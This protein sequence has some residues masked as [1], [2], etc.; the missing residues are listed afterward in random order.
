MAFY[1]DGVKRTAGRSLFQ[2]PVM[3][4]DSNHSTQGWW[5]CLGL[6]EGA[7][8]HGYGTLAIKV[9][10]PAGVR[11]ESLQCCGAFSFY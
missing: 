3:Q 6:F 10:W 11:A 4:G 5:L 1:G 8:R 2:M 7:E 9:Y